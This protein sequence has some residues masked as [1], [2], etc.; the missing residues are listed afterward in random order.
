VAPERVR[1][2]P[3]PFR[4]VTVARVEE[5]SPRMAEVTVRGPELA[6]L[7]VDA[8]AASV[9]VLLPDPGTGRLDVPAWTGNEFLLPDG[10]RPTIRT[11]TPRRLDPAAGELAV[12]V[13]LHGDGAASAWARTAGPGQPAAV[14]GPGRGYPVPRHAGSFLLGGDET[15]LP[16]IG[17]LLEAL[18]D[19]A[20]VAAH[21]EVGAPDARIPLPDRAGATVGWHVLP[22]GQPPGTALVDAVRRAPLAAGTHVWVAGEAAAVQRIRRLLFEERGLPRSRATVRGYWKHGRAG[23]D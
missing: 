5:L 13:V 22:P 3:P 18:P 12:A 14:S 4:Q 16:A 19:G 8:P 2:E 23:S 10:T 7:A 1:R 20:E 6:G 11:L 21:V 9:R 15:A 17:Q